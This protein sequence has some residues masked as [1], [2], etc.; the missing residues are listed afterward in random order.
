MVSCDIGEGVGAYWAH[1]NAVH[2]DIRHI[3]SAVRC[4][5]NGVISTR[6]HNST[7]GYASIISDCGRYGVL[8]TTLKGHMNIMGSINNGE[9][10]VA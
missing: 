6:V 4:Y 7:W 5:V 10:E 1:R 9:G 2:Y 3:I 8:H